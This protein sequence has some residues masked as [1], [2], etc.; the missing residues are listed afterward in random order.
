VVTADDL[1]DY[2]SERVVLATGAQ[3]VT[4]G[5]GP[6]GPDPIA[7]VD[8]AQPQFATPEQ[9]L[10]GKEIASACWSSTP[11][12]ISWASAWPSCSPTAAGA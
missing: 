2:G 12:A 3:W 4:D 9:V 11:T 8:A 7:G 6:L 5:S 10:A 1:L